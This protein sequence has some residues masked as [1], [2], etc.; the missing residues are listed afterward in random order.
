MSSVSLAS[1]RG[2][3]KTRDELG[4]CIRASMLVPGLA[5]PVI[6]VPTGQLAESAWRDE[7]STPLGS[8]VRDGQERMTGRGA[9]LGGEREVAQQAKPS[10]GSSRFWGQRRRKGPMR[11]TREAIV[12]EEGGHVEATSITG[13][14]RAAQESTAIDDKLEPEVFIDAMVFEPLPYRS[15]A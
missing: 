15:E 8:A 1:R 10:R 2:H 11:S 13:T 5:G 9:D 14:G 6:S 7:F 4:R 12:R 3:F